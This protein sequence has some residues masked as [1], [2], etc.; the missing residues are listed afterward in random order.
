[1][2]MHCLI[3]N[4]EGRGSNAEGDYRHGRRLHDAADGADA[5]R[6][7]RLRVIRETGRGWEPYRTTVAAH[8]GLH[9]KVQ[10][11][12]GSLLS[13]FVSNDGVHRYD[14]VV[15]GMRQRI[16]QEAAHSKLVLPARFEYAS[17]YTIMT[18]FWGMYQ[19]GYFDG[20]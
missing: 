17:P 16:L 8:V 10:S 15:L 13:A 7:H 9:R 5:A 20:A 14:G 2:G 4:G 3:P 18:V 11:R 12:T 1:M 6:E 19:R